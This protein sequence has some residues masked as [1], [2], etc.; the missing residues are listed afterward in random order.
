M[1]GYKGKWGC[2]SQL[3]WQNGKDGE[4][5]AL[6]VPVKKAGR[7]DVL[8]QFT[9]ATDYA[10]VQLYW[11]GKKLGEPVDLYDPTVTPS[12]EIKFGTLDLPAADGKLEIEITGKNPKS[13]GRYVGL[14]YLRFVPVNGS[15]Q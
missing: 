3:F 11:D 1:G 5:L 14:D 4:R 8:A 7:F 13:T 6:A 12:G 15:G 9:K 10:I 2:A